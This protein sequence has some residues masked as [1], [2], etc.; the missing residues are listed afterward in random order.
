MPY[1]KKVKVSQLI[2]GID[3]PIKNIEFTRRLDSLTLED[4]SKPEEY[5]YIQLVAKNYINNLD[6]MI[7]WNEG[8][9]CKGTYLGWWNN[10]VI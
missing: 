10:G 4:D 1:E 9:N 6:L 2:N 7:A 3:V 5:D 8:N